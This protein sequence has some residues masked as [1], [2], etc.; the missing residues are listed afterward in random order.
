MGR[1]IAYFHG[2]ERVSDYARAFQAGCRRHGVECALRCA[3]PFEGPE[4]ADVVWMY[5]LGST[6]AVF[7]AYEGGAR[8]VVGDVG[9]FR[10]LMPGTPRQKRYIRVAVDAQQPDRHLRL[11][12]HP[13]DRFE[14]LR[15]SQYPRVETRG[16]HILVCGY[17]AAQAGKFGT[18][19]GRWERETVTKLQAITR[20]PIV[21]REKPKNEPLDIPGTTRCTDDKCW[22]AI[23]K[24]WAVVCRSGNVGADCVLHGVPCFAEMGPGAVYHRQPIEEIDDA[25]QLTP[26]ERMTALSDLAYWSWTQDEIAAGLLWANLKLEGIA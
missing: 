8:R 19:Y 25:R 17:S 12:A 22:Q 5:G 24:A 11:R 4:P 18:E 6:R 2:P 13:A 15:L 23:R 21:V 16:G 10:E 1:A 9:Y 26:D 14:R 20:R 3:E 7:N